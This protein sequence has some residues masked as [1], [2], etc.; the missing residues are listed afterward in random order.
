MLQSILADIICTE[1]QK[2]FK[3]KAEK[4]HAMLLT[5][6]LS[7]DYSKY[8]GYRNLDVILFSNGIN[9]VKVVARERT[10]FAEIIDDAKMSDYV[11]TIGDWEMYAYHDSCWRSDGVGRI[12][13]KYQDDMLVIS[14]H[15]SNT[16]YKKHKLEGEE[17]EAINAL[18]YH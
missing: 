2:E 12:I 3:D 10:T 1:F 9:Y 11:D 8:E 15:F 4:E 7:H 17:R 6:S 16:W 14:N 13:N 18:R 5:F